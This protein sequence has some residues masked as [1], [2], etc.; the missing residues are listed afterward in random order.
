[1]EI[2]PEGNLGNFFN[3]QARRTTTMQWTEVYTKMTNNSLGH[4]LLKLGLDIMRGEF[5]GASSSGTVALYRTDSILNTRID[6]SLPTGQNIHATALGIFGQDHWRIGERLALDFGVRLDR[7]GALAK[8]N[9]APRV[10]AVFSL[11]PKGRAVIRGGAG[12]FY[13]QTPMNVAAFTTYER[14]TVTLLAND[15]I[16]P[17]GP[18]VTWQ[19]RAHANLQT[20][21]G[22]VW[23]L[24]YDHKLSDRW[25]ARLGHMR[26][27]GHH[28]YLIDPIHA[29]TD[30]EYFLDSRGR[31]K[32]R[33]TEL[34][35]RY[36]RGD[37]LQMTWS[38]VRSRSE[39]DLNGYDLFFGNFR[40]PIIRPNE[41]SLTSVDVPDR[42]LYR[43]VLPLPRKIV[44][45][46]ILEA[47]SGFPYSAF[48]EYRRYVGAR[49]RAGRFPSLATLDLRITRPF[50]FWKYKVEA[51][52][53][54]YHL[55][56]SFTPRQ[57]QACVDAR[58]Y[59]IFYNTIAR[60]WGITVTIS[61]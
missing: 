21:Y 55:L 13:A 28:E 46:S 6:Y 2:H 49:N 52:V 58:D 30:P 4:H 29:N 40:D 15:G 50:K 11:L 14:Q 35:I 48:D 31:S 33:E 10:G 61:K 22:L 34:T 60:N 59:G 23:N 5:T 45:S 17:L 3:R 47:R 7:D 18:P 53:F 43:A 57:V 1:M 54:V 16:T 26:R 56:N 32:Y 36:A 51:G 25:T 44:F 42:F 27:Y 8:F 38:F 41:F 20:P 9:L 12:L 37:T 19:N 39:A 24:Q